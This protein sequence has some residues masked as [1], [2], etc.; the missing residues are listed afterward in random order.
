MVVAATTAGGET[1]LLLLGPVSSHQADGNHHDQSGM[2]KNE[3]RR[4]KITRK[5]KMDWQN[6]YLSCNI[7]N[8][9]LLASNNDTTTLLLQLPATFD[10]L[11]HQQQT[12]D[13]KKMVGEW[14]V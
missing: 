10:V 9:L 14:Y 13:L 11:Q 4:M 6:N 5:S 1:V 2:E 12:S 7:I 8:L 3:K